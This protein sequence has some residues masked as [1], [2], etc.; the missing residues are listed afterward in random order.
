LFEKVQRSHRSKVGDMPDELNTVREKVNVHEQKVTDHDSKINLIL[1][2]S[3]ARQSSS[4]LNEENQTEPAGNVGGGLDLGELFSALDQIKSD[5]RNEFISKHLFDE[6]GRRLTKVEEDQSE[7]HLDIES[8]TKKIKEILEKLSGID[9]RLNAESDI[10]Q[11]LSN[12]VKKCEDSVRS[13]VDGD[14]IDSVNTLVHELYE[15]LLELERRGGISLE[16]SPVAHDSQRRASLMPARTS[17]G[18]SSRDNKQMKE[19]QELVS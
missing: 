13:K 14:E 8:N 6:Y 9:N 19:M 5:L 17:V 3:S 16:S 2:V 15:R 18:N 11:D 1:K 7:M 12:K 10:I 4:N